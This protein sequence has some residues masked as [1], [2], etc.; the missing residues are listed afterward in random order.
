MQGE[1]AEEVS[2]LPAWRLNGFYERLLSGL[3]LRFHDGYASA[4]D[5]IVTALSQLAKIGLVRECSV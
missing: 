4:Y 5:L 2:R 3:G 1:E